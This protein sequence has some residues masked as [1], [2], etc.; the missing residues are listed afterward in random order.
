MKMSLNAVEA[1]VFDFVIMN[2]SGTSTG[3]PGNSD[4]S[5]AVVKHDEFSRN[6]TLEIGRINTLIVGDF[7][8]ED[9]SDDDDVIAELTALCTPSL[10]LQYT[11]S[12]DDEDGEDSEDDSDVASAIMSNACSA[13][14]RTLHDMHYHE[15]DGYDIDAP[16]NSQHRLH[17]FC[18]S[19]PDAD[20]GETFFGMIARR[21]PVSD[22]TVFSLVFTQALPFYERDG[23]IRIAKEA[24]ESLVVDES[25]AR[26]ILGFINNV[27]PQDL[28]EK[29]K[30][31]NLLIG[32]SSISTEQDDLVEQL[33]EASTQENQHFSNEYDA[34]TG[35]NVIVSY[36]HSVGDD[37]D[38]STAIIA[39]TVITPLDTDLGIPDLKSVDD[40][41]FDT[42]FERNAYELDIFGTG[43]TPG[44]DEQAVMEIAK[45][46]KGMTKH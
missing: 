39:A 8:N 6:I 24:I 28:L 21:D 20:I 35:I 34:A 31:D 3:A 44:E 42:I 38:A 14:A 43:Y 41:M 45:S 18:I 15:S 46:V 5:T 9:G 10:A 4:P 37:D 11:P 13:L 30:L 40:D 17:I 7:F 36:A 19:S 29:C 1:N 33:Y 27:L 2:F 32:C 26:I 12:P 25:Y 22:E 23:K 16:C